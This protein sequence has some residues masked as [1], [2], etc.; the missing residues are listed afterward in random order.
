MIIDP[1]LERSGSDHY[2]IL[3]RSKSDDLISTVAQVIAILT[4]GWVAYNILKNLYDWFTR[5]NT[6]GHG[7]NPG[8]GG[9]PGGG[10]GG[11]GPGDDG[12]P[13][14]PPPYSKDPTSDTNSYP[15]GSTSSQYPNP[16]D[17]RGGGP[18]A[19]FWTGLAAGGAATYLYN[20]G[21]N[22]QPGL[23]LRETDQ[24]TTTGNG[25]RRRFDW[26]DMDDRGVGPS[27]G[28]GG[29]GGMRRATAFGSS[30]TR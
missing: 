13:Y 8:S 6:L 3:G 23:T 26:E 15:P 10:G 20:R 7:R 28:G 27:T 1:S 22:D 30:S 12:S 16:N 19:G 18:G 9:G 11:G 25:N 29:S 5:R 4:T 17:A 24:R 14:P 2:S 21:R